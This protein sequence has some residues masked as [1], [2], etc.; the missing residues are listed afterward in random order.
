MRTFGE[1]LKSAREEK[2]FSYGYLSSIT[3]VSAKVLEACEKE[4]NSN[5]RIKE[6]KLIC[7]AL[8]LDSVDMYRILVNQ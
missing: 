2:V 6:L 7:D 5:M 8:D 3:G 1:I 4:T